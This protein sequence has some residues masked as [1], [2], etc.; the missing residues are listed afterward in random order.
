M[1]DYTTTPNYDLYKPI[2]GQAETQWA[3]YW[4]NNADLLDGIIKGIEDAGTAVGTSPPANP[5]QGQ[6]WWDANGGQLYIW[7]DDG[8]SAQWVVANNTPAGLGDAPNDANTYGRH[9]GAWTQ[10]ATSAVAANNVGRNLLHNGLFNVAQR[11]VGPWTTGVYTLD[12]WFTGLTSDAI[13][14]SQ[15]T[16]ADA[17][18]AA[19]G[20]E[21][22]SVALQNVFTGNAAAGAFN[23]LMQRIEGMRRVSGKTV[24]VSFWARASVAGL[25]VGVSIDQNPGSGG[26]PSA[27]VNGNGVAVTLATTWAK[28]SASIVVPSAAG[29]T[30]G[31]NGDSTTQ[32]DFWYSAG[33]TMAMRAG[34]I[35][36]QSGT[37]QLWGVQLEI[38]SVATPLDY[39]G[40][41]ED[42]TR[43]CLRFYQANLF[44]NLN[45]YNTAGANLSY[46]MTLFVPMRAIPTVTT[47]GIGTGN[48]SNPTVGT[49]TPTTIQIA[50]AC[51]A[52]GAAFFN[53]TAQASADL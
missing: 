43:Q 52:A 47:S 13:S 30:L 36:V 44:F 11:G 31:T 28:Y 33:A 6:Q 18:R 24:T 4:N 7:Y 34:N 19:I 9:A 15:I 35:G 38:G 26:S 32:L 42:Q 12:R 22:A 17:D 27:S 40:T 1:S 29:L 14:F 48:A 45:G 46:T 2:V 37:V 5:T 39:G 20:D 25:K 16:L 23:L 50:C 49:N 51:T 8:N 21:A 53:G 3:V 41:L 10:V